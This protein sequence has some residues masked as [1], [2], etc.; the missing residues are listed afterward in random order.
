MPS[1]HRS[2]VAG[3][4]TPARTILV[5]GLVVGAILVSL[6]ATFLAVVMF[7]ENGQRGLTTQD[8]PPPASLPEAV[9]PVVEIA[10]VPVP[11]AAPV[12]VAPIPK[13]PDPPPDHSPEVAREIDLRIAKAREAKAKADLFAYAAS[14]AADWLREKA[15][16][17][18]TSTSEVLGV[19]E[20]AAAETSRLKETASQIADAVAR[21][22]LKRDDAM[23]RLEAAQN[24]KGY[25]I[26]PYRGPNGA[27]QRPLPI[28]CS[29]DT[30]Q[31]MPGGPTFRLIDLELSGLTRNSLF[32]RIVELAVRKAAAQATPDGNAPTVYVLFIV[33]PSG[34]KAYYE[35]RARLQAQGVAFGYEL[36][37]ETTQ[38]D[39]PDL[40][41]LTEWPGYVPSEEIVDAIASDL[42]AGALAGSRPVGNGG[43]S[44]TGSAGSRDPGLFVWH[45]GLDGKRPAGSIDGPG[46]GTQSP[47]GMPGSSAGAG[48]DGAQGGQGGTSSRVDF[49]P[50]TLSQL[51]RSRS[52]GSAL[53]ALGANPGTG[54]ASGSRSSVP[55]LEPPWGNQNDPR[56][57]SGGGLNSPGGP[58]G[59]KSSG[60]GTGGTFEGL[61]EELQ[62]SGGYEPLRSVTRP[63]A[64]PILPGDLVD[65]D[66]ESQASPLGGRGQS[67]TN[68]QGGGSGRNARGNPAGSIGGSPFGT[69]SP[70][71]PRFESVSSGTQ[72]SS[73]AANAP[74]PSGENLSAENG[75]ES[76][77]PSGSPPVGSANRQRASG[78][79][80]GSNSAGTPPAGAE[81]SR[82]TGRSRN[83]A[84]SSASGAGMPPSLSGSS[85]NPSGAPSGGSQSA[86]SPSPDGS[87]FGIRNSFKRIF[88]G[89]DRLPEQAWEVNLTCDA[90]GLTIRPGE[91]RLSLNDMQTDPDLLPRTLQS[92]FERQVRE[93]PERYWRPYVKYRL[94]AGGEPLM[95]LSQNH[96]AQGFVRWPAVVE[97][98]ATS[99]R[100]AAR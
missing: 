52:N 64:I 97:P 66:S 67:D 45:N 72:G 75:T 20:K 42:P 6:V 80:I 68:R 70:A 38:I 86:G 94:A 14:K 65:D 50:G 73:L 40:G 82:E 2:P 63:G 81:S 33:R 4:S 49:G 57:P 95:G 59:D 69:Q 61:M 100:E 53:A 51:G 90:D 46:G 78:S 18:E 41:D 28:E 17:T 58:L 36:V 32:A 44:A 79:G 27:W 96:L 54:S 48:I 39:Y 13:Q 89:E 99:E 22:E 87:R 10:P 3:K 29:R 91:H 47:T 8:A 83:A 15:K 85:S 12:V 16:E 9:P 93:N 84:G 98:A 25:S 11:E 35:S 5:E 56:R 31:I 43:S 21:L 60:N 88:G 34:I 76:G 30:A 55:N 92:M 1:D 24:R 7:L 62:S 71:L 19:G 77:S 23:A 37:D 26:L 74:N